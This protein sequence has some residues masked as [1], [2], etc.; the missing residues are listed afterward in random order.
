MS[1]NKLKMSML[2]LGKNQYL[3]NQPKDNGELIMLS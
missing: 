3:K 2:N 1:Y